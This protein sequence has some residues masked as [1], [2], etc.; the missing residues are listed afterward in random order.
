MAAVPMVTVAGRPRTLAMAGGTIALS[1]LVVG[2]V[3]TVGPGLEEAVFVLAS[4]GAALAVAAALDGFS[5]DIFRLV[6]A[7]GGIAIL[8]LSTISLGNG[9]LGLP[10]GDV[11]ARLSFATTLAGDQGPGRILYASINREIIPGEVRSGPGFWYR[12][13]DG[14]GTTLD[15]VWLP[16]DQDG[17]DDLATALIEIASGAELRPG[18]RLAAFAIDWVVLEGPSFVLDDV[19]IAQL[20]LVP[21]P[22][23]PDS[24][25]YEND[26]AVTLA[27]TEQTPWLA[28]GVGYGGEVIDGRAGVAANFD[29]GWGPDGERSGWSVTVDGSTGRAGWAAPSA[30]VV[31]SVVSIVAL[32]GAMGA[33]ALGRRYPSDT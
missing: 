31:M 14:R 5:R 30:R 2:R 8:V 32:V 18:Q 26:R 12:V 16:E 24:R 10:P 11:N 15:E 6:A 29:D 3:A 33:I 21:L 7:I 23:D 20:D 17:D 9:R 27:G 1:S 13:L 25:V 28:M 19:L 4:F 22:L